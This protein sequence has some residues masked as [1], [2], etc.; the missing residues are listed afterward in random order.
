LSKETFDKAQK[1]GRDKTRYALIKCGFDQ[2]LSWVLIRQ[3]IYSRLW[4]WSGLAMAKLGLDSN[5]T[6]RCQVRG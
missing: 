4:A 1:Y 2:L 6:V 5:R 3:G